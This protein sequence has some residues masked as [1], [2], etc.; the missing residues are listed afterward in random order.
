MET[1]PG[2]GR[3]RLGH[4]GREIAVLRRNLLHEGAEGDDPVRGLQHRAIADVDLH[5]PRRVLG[6]RLLDGDPDP[7]ELAPDGAEHVLELRRPAKPVHLVS[8]IDRPPGL[9]VEQVE[10]ELR[11]DQDLEPHRL[12]AGDL[13]LEGAAG[14]DGDG[15][16]VRA[17]RAPEAERAPFL[18]RDRVR[19]RPA[20]TMC[21]S[22]YPFSM[23]T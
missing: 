21:M 18:P 3:E 8:D 15:L 19:T 20:G 10:L 4:E 16:M 14:V 5:L 13:R 12:R 9:R 17:E 11:P 6:V 23:L 1:A 2:L 22:G 7:G